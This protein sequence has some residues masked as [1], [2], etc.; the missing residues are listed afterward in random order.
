MSVGI[1]FT[2]FI[3]TIILKTQ[4]PNKAAQ[5][6]EKMVSLYVNLDK[7]INCFCSKNNHSCM[8]KSMINSTM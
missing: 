2:I 4:V 8:G 5:V 1:I 7:I 6:F 3:T